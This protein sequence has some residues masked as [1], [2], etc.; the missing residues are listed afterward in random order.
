MGVPSPYVEDPDD[1]VEDPLVEACGA[2]VGAAEDD[3]PDGAL[4]GSAEVELDDVV[5]PSASSV[6][7]EPQAISTASARIVV[8]VSRILNSSLRNM[9][10][11]TSAFHHLCP[12]YGQQRKISSLL[13]YRT[14]IVNNSTDFV[15]VPASKLRF[16][17][18][19]ITI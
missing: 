14:Q 12:G 15:R 3:E 13:A 10:P 4:V 11:G 8:M 18:Q 19:V 16:M 7:E 6:A 2:S 1:V 5:P 17:L 9:L